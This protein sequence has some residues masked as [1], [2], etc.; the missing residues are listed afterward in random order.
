MT[1]LLSDIPE[2]INL[3]QFQTHLTELIENIKTL[4]KGD[5]DAKAI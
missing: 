5:T 4:P 1:G 3:A 2:A